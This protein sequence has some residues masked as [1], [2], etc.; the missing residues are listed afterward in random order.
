MPISHILLSLHELCKS[1]HLWSLSSTFTLFD[2]FLKYVAGCCVAHILWASLRLL[3]RCEYSRLGWQEVFKETGNQ[4]SLR[5]GDLILSK[6]CCG[7]WV[8]VKWKENSALEGS[9]ASFVWCAFTFRGVAMHL[10]LVFY[11]F[12]VVFFTLRKAVMLIAPCMTESL[13][14][15]KRSHCKRKNN[16][17]SLSS[18]TAKSTCD[19]CICKIIEGWQIK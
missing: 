7:H 5:N 18:V 10:Q 16:D 3:V 9:A 14:I 2:L 13:K 8:P 4:D 11:L 17:Y 12:W 15:S 1:P 19:K 6:S